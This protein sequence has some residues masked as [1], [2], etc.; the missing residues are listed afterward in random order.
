MRKDLRRSAIDCGIK[1][2]TLQNDTIATILSVMSSVNVV[3]MLNK[4]DQ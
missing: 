2:G 1:L 4:S 3:D